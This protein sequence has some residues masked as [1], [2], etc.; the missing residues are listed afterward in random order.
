M[1]AVALV[2]SESGGQGRYVEPLCTSLSTNSQ[3]KQ[4]PQCSVPSPTSAETTK[5]SASARNDDDPDELLPVVPA[6]TR[7]RSRSKSRSVAV[8]GAG[9][10][11]DARRAPLT[12]ICWKTAEAVRRLVRL[13][14][15]V[16]PG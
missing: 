13:Y 16:I 5:A 9:L 12:E 15:L 2:A 7:L 3:P 8:L 14:A 1:C 10:E 4:S 11:R 6:L